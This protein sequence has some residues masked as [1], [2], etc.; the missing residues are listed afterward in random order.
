MGGL[1]VLLVLGLVMI[2]IAFVIAIIIPAVPYVLAF[3]GVLAIARMLVRQSERK[4][5]T[6]SPVRNRPGI[7]PVK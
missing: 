3:I 6:H 5:E 7:E 1:K 2:V 4:D